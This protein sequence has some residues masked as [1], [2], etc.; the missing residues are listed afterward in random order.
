MRLIFRQKIYVKNIETV[1]P[2]W[3]KNFNVFLSKRGNKSK[4]DFKWIRANIP[5]I[6]ENESVDFLS[7]LQVIGFLKISE[8]HQDIRKRGYELPIL[9]DVSRMP[10]VNI[11]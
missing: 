11:I 1:D 9:Y 2:K 8:S 3:T 4:F 10:K 6:S 5:G 7:F